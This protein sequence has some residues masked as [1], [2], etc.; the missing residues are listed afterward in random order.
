[1][2]DAAAI[3]AHDAGDDK[4][5]FDFEAMPPAERY[6]IAV[7]TVVP[8]P[9]GWVSSLSASGVVNVAPFSF[10]NIFCD[11]PVMVVLGLMAR[12]PSQWKD[13]P[14]NIL[15]SGEFVVHVVPERLAEAMNATC[16]DMPPDVSEADVAGLR[17]VP[18]TKVR[19]PRL[20]D[21]PAAFECRVVH[22]IPNGARGVLVISKVVQAHL[23]RT[24][25]SGPTDRPQVDTAAMGL[26]A[27][28]HGRGF[29]TRTTDLFDMPRPGPWTRPTGQP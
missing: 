12:G 28:M 22:T 13:T 27:R 5:P 1:M 25:L 8:R 23:S 16:A 7:N 15:A 6:R 2:T 14:A 20:A 11:D 26:I 29:Y 17:L 24:L 21:S 4:Q 19:P 9:I 3:S 10:F 18:S